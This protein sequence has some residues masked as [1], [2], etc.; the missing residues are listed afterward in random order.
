MFNKTPQTGVL[1]MTTFIESLSKALP[2]T[3]SR[4]VAASHLQGILSQGTLANL[5][6]RGEGPESVRIGRCVCYERETFL[7]WLSGRIQS[8]RPG[9]ASGSGAA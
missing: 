1:H 2:V 5:D 8:Q 7:R 3:F 6:S 9:R 4:S